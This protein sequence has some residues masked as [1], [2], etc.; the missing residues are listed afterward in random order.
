MRITL[1]LI[2]NLLLLITYSVQAQKLDYKQGEIIVQLKDNESVKSLNQYLVNKNAIVNGIKPLSK[3]AGIYLISLDHTKTNEYQMVKE[4]YGHAAIKHA[5]LNSIVEYRQIIP[6]DPMFNRQW[7]WQNTGQSNGITGSDINITKAWEYTTGGTTSN[8]DT[9]VVAVLDSG[10]DFDHIDLTKNLWINHEEIP[11]D[12]IDNDNNG[13]VDDYYGWNFRTDT[14]EVNN[15]ADHGTFIAGLI[16]GIGNNGTGITGVNWNIKVMNLVRTGPLNEATVIEGYDYALQKRIAYNESNGERGAFVVAINSS[17]GI[18][19]RWGENYPLWCDFYNLLGENGILSCGATS[20]SPTNVDRF[21][22]MPTTCDSEYLMTVTAVDNRDRRNFSGYGANHIDM[23]APG[24]NVFSSFEFNN[25]SSDSGTSYATPIVAGA[26][27]L[28]Y[29]YPCDKIS[30]LTADNPLKSAA[31]I[32]DAIFNGIRK[33]DGLSNFTKYGGT[34]DVLAS[35]EILDNICNSCATIQNVSNTITDKTATINWEDLFNEANVSKNLLFRIVGETSW[36]TIS[37][38]NPPLLLNNL[39][40]D[41]A[42]EFFIEASCENQD[43]KSTD[44]YQF[45]TD[46]SCNEIVDIL[47]I[48]PISTNEHQVTWNPLEVD[49]YTLQFKTKEE[50]IWQTFYVVDT[51][52]TIETYQNCS[53][54]EVR[55][56]YFCSELDLYVYG[57]ITTLVTAGCEGCS[58]RNYCPALISENNGEFFKSITLNDWNYTA[59]NAENPNE[60]LPL[61]TT[62]LY[63]G[64]T[65]DMELIPGFEAS[66]HLVHM[67]VWVDFNQN[68]FLEDNYELILSTDTTSIDTVYTSFVVPS[69]AIPGI[70]RIRYM[71]YI[72]E[73]NPT[74]CSEVDFGYVREF[75]IEIKGECTSINNIEVLD[76]TSTTI[77]VT[78]EKNDDATIAYTYRYRALGADIWNEEKLTSG[79]SVHLTG[80]MPCTEYELQVKNICRYDSTEFKTDIIVETSCPLSGNE[81]DWVIDVNIYPNPFVDYFDFS[82]TSPLSGDASIEIYTMDGKQIIKRKVNVQ[83]GQQNIVRFDNIINQTGVFILIF[84]QEN[85]L[86]SKKIIKI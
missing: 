6:N 69:N 19:N 45:K 65:Y 1:T 70:T 24:D 23:A 78:W 21:G 61:S 74:S 38:D 3:T 68:G 12:G 4:L 5:Q 41:T 7:M 11:N 33:V 77:S 2:V 8:G 79:N 9:I 63:T 55:V 54:F 47:D 85:K 10:V 48:N 43:S 66:E 14:D 49:Y 83:T 37:V 72:D 60:Y 42:Y 76:T 35:M 18:D 71:M 58:D 44:T 52:F 29:S 46:L 53:E 22:D 64:R 67:K 32:R 40:P 20:N 73:D 26:I 59:E 75:C 16:G 36:D 62:E 28:L 82:I 34:L 80:L 51:T 15:K 27:G 81:L 57:N 17:F 25:Y 30:Q 86:V 84:R 39:L 13:Y 56:G 50:T 31:L